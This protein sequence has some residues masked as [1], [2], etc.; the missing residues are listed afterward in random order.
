MK[1]LHIN[2]SDDPS[3]AYISA[4]QLHEWC[5]SEGLESKVLVLNQNHGTKSNQYHF[6]DYIS[7]N[8]WEKLKLFYRIRF[9]YKFYRLLETRLKNK[10][11]A[12]HFVATPYRLNNHP[13]VKEADIIHLHQTSNFLNWNSFFT[14]VNKPIIFTFHDYEPI[15]EGYHLQVDSEQN[16]FHSKLNL[17]LKKKA[18]KKVVSVRKVTVSP[19]LFQY[20][21]MISSGLFE[22]WEHQVIHHPVNIRNESLHY[23]QIELPESYV[24]FIASDLSR[25]EKGYH[26]LVSSI[27]YLHGSN[28]KLVCVGDNKNISSCPDVFYTGKVTNRGLLYN[29]IEN[30]LALIVASKEESF[31]LVYLEA[32]LYNKPIISS[33]VGLTE[34]LIKLNANIKIINDSREILRFIGEN[35]AEFKEL[36]N[37]CKPNILPRII[38]EAKEQYLHLYSNI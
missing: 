10:D 25:K 37:A 9:Q 35:N 26:E 8:F 6:W 1:I 27:N 14:K 4:W 32:L 18:L 23:N 15:S 22:G 17:W 28:I 2:A 19:T 21:R 7:D 31:G 36:L 11:K 30:S 12:F 16:S 24:V 33:K 34:D 3:G 29:I 20:N 38:A 5:L 13:L